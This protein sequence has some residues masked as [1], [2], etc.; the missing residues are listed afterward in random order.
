MS[1]KSDFDTAASGFITADNTLLAA[2]S[3]GATIVILWT[4]WV[5]VKA[6]NDWT[7]GKTKAGQMIF[8]WFRAVFVLMV[9]LFLLVN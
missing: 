2:Q 9:I 5:S 4:A 7:N 3:I 1:W 8:I 6:Y